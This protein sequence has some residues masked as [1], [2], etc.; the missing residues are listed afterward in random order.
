MSSSRLFS[1]ANSV[2]KGRA[3][4]QGPGILSKF[5]N[6]QSINDEDEVDFDPPDGLEDELDSLMGAL[7][8]KVCIKRNF[9][10]Y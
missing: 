8:D 2:D 4:V 5:S 7:S 1:K 9:T 6:D 3:V 10:R